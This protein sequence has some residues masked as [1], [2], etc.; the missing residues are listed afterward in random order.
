MAAVVTRHRTRPPA[1]AGRRAAIGSRR[2]AL[3]EVRPGVL[4]RETVAVVTACGRW[5]VERLDDERTTWTVAVTD[6]DVNAAVGPAL[7]GIGTLGR[8]LEQIADGT[9]YRALCAKAGVAP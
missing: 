4:R 3:V 8:A 6:D 2:Y 9:A 7:N 5:V 1:P